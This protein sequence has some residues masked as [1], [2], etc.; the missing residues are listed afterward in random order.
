MEIQNLENYHILFEK[1]ITTIHSARLKVYKS[2]TNHQIALNFEL[3]KL[4]VGSQE[5]QGWGKSVVDTFSKDINKVIDGTKGYSP[6]NL[7][8][9]RQFYLE[10]KD[11]P[12]L[13]SLIFQV[14]WGQNLL[15][16]RKIKLEEER[17]YYLQSTIQLAW[18]RAVLLNQIKA[19]AYEHH[20][21]NKK[22]P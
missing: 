14:P 19:K 6:Q 13:K 3:G 5:S 21:V 22:T 1:I 2:L 8:F 10:Y 20:L 7:W 15:I 17:K 16:M 12:D 4:I 18:S 11:M 9:M